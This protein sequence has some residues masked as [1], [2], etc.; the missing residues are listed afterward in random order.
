MLKSD[1][2]IHT[3]EDPKDP[4]IK[5]T[6]KDLITFASKKGFEVLSITLHDHVL[7]KK[8]IF[9]FARQKGI[10]LIP[11]VEAQIEGKHVLIYNTTNEEITKIKNLID[12]EKIKDHAVIAAPHPF[13]YLGRCLGSKLIENIKL[14]DAIEYN[15]YYWRFLNPNRK[16]VEVAKKFGLPLIGNSDLHMIYQM[17]N[18]FSNIDSEKTKDDVLEAIRKGNLRVQT[19]PPSF[20]DFVKTTAFILNPLC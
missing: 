14:F 7:N 15:H 16:A 17:N 20:F 1:M 19:K 6:A 3:K 12:L 10:L 13:Y 9:D 18:T 2:H 8:H 11:G 4:Y 5:Y